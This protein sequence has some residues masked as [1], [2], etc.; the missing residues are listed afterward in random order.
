MDPKH[1]H[2][3]I[4]QT[5]DNNMW[6]HPRKEISKICRAI[7][8]EI[9]MWLIKQI[10]NQIYCHIQHWGRQIRICLVIAKK[11]WMKKLIKIHS[12]HL[13]AKLVT[14]SQKQRNWKLVSR[15]T[16]PNELAPRSKILRKIHKIQTKIKLSMMSLIAYWVKTKRPTIKQISIKFIFLGRNKTILMIKLKAVKIN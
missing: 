10:T 8:Q 14:W 13:R 5:M 6:S 12:C 2:L 9:M 11:K 16:P 7:L 1:H 4:E 3:K 15:Q